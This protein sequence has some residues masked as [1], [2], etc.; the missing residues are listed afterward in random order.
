MDHGLSIR[1]RAY[2]ETFAASPR[3]WRAALLLDLAAGGTG[4]A[5]AQTAPPPA[6]EVN[7][8]IGSLHGGNTFPGVVMPFGMLQRSPENTRGKHTHTASSSG[9][10]YDALRIRSFSLTHLSGAG[11]RDA[12][13]DVPFMPVTTAVTSSPSADATDSIYASDF[14]Q[15]NEHARAGDYRVR[16]ANGVRVEFGAATR[17]GLAS[18]RFPVG[19]PAN[20]LIRASDAEV[21]SSDSHRRAYRSSISHVPIRHTPMRRTACR[22]RRRNTADDRGVV[23][24]LRRMLHEVRRT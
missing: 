3:I 10:Q 17:S 8:L 6:D 2:G 19:K 4:D 24:T 23:A 18:F 5:I 11:C 20:L 15:A 13:G 21:G 9:Y 16:L 1:Q 22:R 12:S 7:P 14:S